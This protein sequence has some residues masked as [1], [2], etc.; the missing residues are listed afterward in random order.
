MTAPEP[1]RPTAE[2]IDAACEVMHDAYERA[3]VGA[4][5]ETNPANLNTGVTRMD[6]VYGHAEWLE[7]SYVVVGDRYLPSKIEVVF[8]GGTDSPQPGLEFTIEV[9]KEIPTVTRVELKTR[10]GGRGIRPSDLDDIRRRLNDWTE[11]IVAGSMMEVLSNVEG[12]LVVVDRAD[13]HRANARA[14]RAMQSGGRRKITTEHLQRVAE[15]YREH[16]EG[17]PIEAVEIA[18]GTSYRSAARWVQKAREEGLL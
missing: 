7:D 13:A 3:A 15:V 5:W 8:P 9:V 11:D 1:T 17:T 18:F 10:E 6:L 2:H 14:A 16:E 4:G 12:R